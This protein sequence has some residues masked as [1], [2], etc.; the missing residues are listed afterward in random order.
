MAFYKD[1]ISC[2][3]DMSAQ[4]NNNQQRVEEVCNKRAR[5]SERCAKPDT[6]IK[7]C[8]PNNPNFPNN[9]DES[10]YI[11]CGSDD[12]D[13]LDLRDGAGSG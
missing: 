4:F 1:W 9:L 5:R 13:D 2:I 7:F 10:N 11:N 12:Y 3:I 6:E 8:N